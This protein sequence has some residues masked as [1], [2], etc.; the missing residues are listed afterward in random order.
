MG[1]S[2]SLGLRS[3]SNPPRNDAAL[4][5]AANP[6][7][8]LAATD[9]VVGGLK[10]SLR[11]TD[12]PREALRTAATIPRRAAMAARRHHR[13][14]PLKRVQHEETRPEASKRLPAP[15]PR[16]NRSPP[17]P[18]ILRFPHNCGIALCGSG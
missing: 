10:D 3:V 5:P 16:L 17:N 9:L 12:A 7:R 1:K 4:R 8:G 11:Q 15:A 6:L 13:N 2:R 18:R 14:N